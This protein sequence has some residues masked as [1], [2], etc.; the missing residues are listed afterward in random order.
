[1]S[2]HLLGHGALK[3]HQVS[4]DFKLAMSVVI[5]V[6][7]FSFPNCTLPSGWIGCIFNA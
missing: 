2:T 6:G 5:M 1:M 7:G 4:S 3:F